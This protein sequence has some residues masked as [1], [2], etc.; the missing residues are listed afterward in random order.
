ML[1]RDGGTRAQENENKG[2]RIHRSSV[3]APAVTHKQLVGRRRWCWVVIAVRFVHMPDEDGW[4]FL[5]RVRVVVERA[6]MQFECRLEKNSI[7]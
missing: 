5:E 2:W 1:S 7:N 4:A 3:V 6:G